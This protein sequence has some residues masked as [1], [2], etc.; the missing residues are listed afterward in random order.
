MGEATERL[1]DQNVRRKIEK[2]Q[3]DGQ[4]KK[5][6]EFCQSAL[7]SDPTNAD[8]HISLGDLYLDWHLDIFQAKQYINEAITEYQRALESNLNSNI[9]HYKIGV[10][11]YHKGD[12]DKA[13]SQF[14]L[15]IEYNEK[16]ADAYLMLARCLTKKDR[17]VE[18]IANAEKAIK[19]GGLKSSR[20]HYLIH[21]LLTS[22][23]KNTFKRRIKA[24]CELALSLLT[25]PFE[26]EAMK[27]L[28]KKLLYLKF[29]PTIL[30]GYY[31]EKS[32]NIY[33]AIDLYNQTIEEAP[34]FLPIYLLL[35]DLYKTLGRYEEAINEYRMVLWID[36]NNISAHKS[37]CQTYEEQ[38]D[39]D[40]SVEM[41]RSLIQ[42]NPNDAILYSNLA[43]ILYLKG[44][45]KEAISCYHHAITLNPSKDWTSVIAQTLGYVFQESKNNYDAAIS[46]Y[47]SAALLNPDDIDLYISLGSAFYDKGDFEN[48][49]SVYRVALELD[50]FNAKIHCNL[51][52]LLWGKGM[53]N[54]SIK[55]YE[56]SIHY[57]PEYDIAYNNLGVIYLDDLFMIQKAI[58]QFEKAIKCNPNYALAYYNLGR[59]VST[60]GDKIEAA[61]LYQVALDLN[62][63]TN[64]LDSKEVEDRISELFD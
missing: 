45:V 12:L 22:G 47:H 9:I 19:H 20:A 35:G 49:L 18:A 31:L 6:I 34:G 11:L 38:G 3:R 55:E 8:L 5:A 60:K 58:D 64:E 42:I 10:A 1:V 62:A 32:K 2:M 25:M 52:Y 27:E 29:F 40:S 46:A 56:L 43:N 59:A 28:W 24:D 63:I 23:F 54:E 37:L 15:A 33:K 13:I 41:Y 21:S 14:S 7:Q 53:I 17:Y 57:D 44:E 4:F 61:R 16:M 50:P 51:G 30:R 48:A 39:Y 26:P 36:P